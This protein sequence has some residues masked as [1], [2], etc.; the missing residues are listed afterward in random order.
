MSVFKVLVEQLGKIVDHYN[1][2]KLRE[3]NPHDLTL[4]QN[5]KS[6]FS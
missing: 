6:T 3:T 4:M 2:M 5:M 1:L